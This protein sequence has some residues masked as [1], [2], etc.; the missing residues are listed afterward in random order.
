MDRR[1][2]AG[3]LE[4]HADHAGITI[5]RTPFSSRRNML[6]NLGRDILFL[7]YERPTEY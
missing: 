7:G 3:K 2:V 1:A 4:A 6:R 5:F